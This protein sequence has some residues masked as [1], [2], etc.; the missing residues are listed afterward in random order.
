MCLPFKKFS[1][2]WTKEEI[3]LGLKMC[4]YINFKLILNLKTQQNCG[5]IENILFYDAK[6]IPI[7]KKVTANFFYVPN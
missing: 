5:E 4:L 3:N 1:K 6:T 2:P 7:A